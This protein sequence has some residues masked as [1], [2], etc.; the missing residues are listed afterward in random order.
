MPYTPSTVP[1]NVPKKYAAQFS[2][3]WNSAYAAAIADKKS[4][5][6]AEET[7]FAQAHGVILKAKQKDER[8][9][10]SD[11]PGF[12]PTET[13]SEDGGQVSDPQQSLRGKKDKQPRDK[14]GRFGSDKYV[15]TFKKGDRLSDGKRSVTLLDY[16]TSRATV[17]HD[18]GETE[19][20]ESIELRDSE[21]QPR[22]PEGK[23]V[24]TA[25]ESAH[26]SDEHLAAQ[27]DHVGKA[28]KALAKGDRDTAQAHSDAGILHSKAAFAT[29]EEREA[30]GQ[31][32]R[33]AS[34][35]ANEKSG[36]K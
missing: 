12:G 8:D 14:K 18:D 26:T 7:A 23:F 6:Q 5:A 32:A 10:S 27:S 29:D 25:G 24:S 9:V 36:I 4:P 31:P 11:G 30:V 34:K 33:D 13:K 22:V 28:R 16:T 17:Q 20:V 19:Q 2:E 21:D 35:V 1:D 15:N 3:V